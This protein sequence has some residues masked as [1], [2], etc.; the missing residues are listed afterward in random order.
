MSMT[1]ERPTEQPESKGPAAKAPG[2]PLPLV[3]NLGRTV[4]VVGPVA[5]VDVNE[6]RTR[7]TSAAS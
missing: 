7:R 5:N 6:C 3:P 1:I 2:V 4:P